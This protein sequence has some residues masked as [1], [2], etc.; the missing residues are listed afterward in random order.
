MIDLSL[1]K[2]RLKGSSLNGISHNLSCHWYLRKKWE[3][4]LLKSFF[5]LK[6][7]AIF[8]ISKKK[9]CDFMC[10]T[11]YETIQHWHHWHYCWWQKIWQVLDP[12]LVLQEIS[13]YCPKKQKLRVWMLFTSRKA[14]RF[15]YFCVGNCRSIWIIFYET[16]KTFSIFRKCLQNHLSKRH[17]TTSL[18]IKN[19]VKSN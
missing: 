8:E 19:S 9:K 11:W 1:A 2:K 10:H 3:K 6:K 13:Q 14:L 17:Y 5:Y 4:I 16:F 7:E 18:L 15:V 12:R